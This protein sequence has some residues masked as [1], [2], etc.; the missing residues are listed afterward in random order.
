M[1][2]IDLKEG[3]LYELLTD[4]LIWYIQRAGLVWIRT[5]LKH[6]LVKIKIV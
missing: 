4:V 5:A 3:H 2:K 6:K 1:I